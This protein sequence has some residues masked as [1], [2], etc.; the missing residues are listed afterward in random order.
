MNDINV[1][2]TYNTIQYY[3]NFNFL[4]FFLLVDGGFSEWTEFSKCS[5]S[6]GE[7][8]RKRT[9]SCTNP[10]PAHNGKQCIG[11]TVETEDCKIKECPG[12]SHGINILMGT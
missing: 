3:N 8:S 5:A 4:F 11:E 12:I 10:L 7:G 9:R 6:C 1:L 2:I